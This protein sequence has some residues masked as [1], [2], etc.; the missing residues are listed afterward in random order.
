MIR[1]ILMLILLLL[2]VAARAQ[3]NTLPAT[4]LVASFA[5]EQLTARLQANPLW[6]NLNKDQLGSPLLLR[7]SHTFIPTAAGTASGLGSAIWA[8]GT[9]GLLPVVENRD[10]A[11]TYDIYVNGTL[12]LSYSYQRNFTRAFSMYSKNKGDDV[13]GDEAEAWALQTV[14]QFCAQAAQD[15]RINELLAEYRFYFSGNESRR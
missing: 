6:A 14:E 2:P 3:S 12:L 15:R 9:L 5:E 8:G 11:I 4:R 1:H 10:L 13:L 7:V